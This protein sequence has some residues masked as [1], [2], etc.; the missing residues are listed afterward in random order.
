MKE[1]RIDFNKVGQVTV[2]FAESV[3]HGLQYFDSILAA[4]F[5]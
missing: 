5:D 1:D 2:R 3:N 4:H